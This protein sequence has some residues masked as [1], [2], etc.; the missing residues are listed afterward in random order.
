MQT[1]LPYADF[2]RCASVLDPNR[3]YKQC[4][5]GL[6]LLTLFEQVSAGKEFPKFPLVYEMWEGHELLLF[7]YTN[8]MIVRWLR[9]TRDGELETLFVQ[10]LRHSVYDQPELPRTQP[11]WLGDE[12][13]HSNH[14]GRLLLK[15]ALDC[16]RERLNHVRCSRGTLIKG[17]HRNV[18]NYSLKDFAAVNKQLDELG[19]P[20]FTNWYA[21]FGW[22]EKMT[23]KKYWPQFQDK[24]EDLWQIH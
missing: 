24:S 12:R 17:S 7:D 11:T 14:R 5:D 8:S 4:Y 16:T 22:I 21:Q 3:L 20:T 18:R 2:E 9:T 19:T 1:F 6:Q 23:D 10:H 13:L 15:G